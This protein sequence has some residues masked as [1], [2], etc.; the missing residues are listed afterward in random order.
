MKKLICAKMPVKETEA[1]AVMLCEDDVPAE[2]YI[3]RRGGYTACGDIFVGY[4]ENIIPPEGGAFVRLT[5]GERGYLP[6]SKRRNIV[7]KTVKKDDVLK[8]GDEILVR[9]ETESAAGKHAVLNCSLKTPGNKDIIEEIKEKGLHRPAGTCLYKAP[10]RWLEILDKNA[11]EEFSRIVTD[12][13]T[14][15]EDLGGRAAFYD[16][17]LVSLYKLYNMTTVL[18]R[19]LAKKVWLQSGAY[20]F[21]EKTEAFT[22]IDVNSGKI[23]KKSGCEEMFL[24]VNKQAAVEIFRQFRL[25]H[26]SGSVL[27][28][29]IS[30]KKDESIAELF[31]FCQELAKSDPVYVNVV[32]ITKLGIMEITRHKTVR[33]LSAQIAAL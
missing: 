15:F 4:V 9:V 28:D 8:P 12:D 20:I 33:P 19:A 31:S 32:D 23:S 13:E 7:Y 17:K 10:R 25:R 5:E 2:L 22:V 3:E 21:I 6:P 27:V 16:D 1:I 18:D 24:Q 29:F 11:G 26:I 30:M 14:V